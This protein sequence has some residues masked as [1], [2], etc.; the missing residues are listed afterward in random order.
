M[1]FVLLSPSPDST[2]APAPK[3]SYR[4][5]SWHSHCDA[6]Q[7]CATECWTGRCDAGKGKKTKFCQPCEKCINPKDSVSRGC[8]ICKRTSMCAC[9]CSRLTSCGNMF[10]Y[11]INVCHEHTLCMFAL[12][13]QRVSRA[14][15]RCTRLAIDTW[16]VEP[17]S[18]AVSSAGP[19]A[20][21]KPATYLR[22]EREHTVSRVKSAKSVLIL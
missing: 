17:N 11:S 18:S 22:A 4:A 7:F 6:N 3:R 14:P 9:Q 19:A 5:C 8:Q 2:L 21:A 13:N 16:I 12:Q 1:P 15:K 10:M 20:V